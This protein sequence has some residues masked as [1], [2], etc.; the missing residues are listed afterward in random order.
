LKT[1]M[2]EQRN[3]SSGAPHVGLEIADS[4]TRLTVTL[5]AAAG[6]RR[7]H[8]RLPTAP[9]PAAALDAIHALIARALAD[10]ATAHT[11]TTGPDATGAEDVSGA[12]DDDVSGNGDRSASLDASDTP[13]TPHAIGVAFWGAVDAARGQLAGTFGARLASGWEGFPL[14]ERL[15]TRWGGPVRVETATNA[16]ALAEAQLGAGRGYDGVFYML[17]GRSVTSA[18]VIG[19]RVWRGA[20]GR[21]GML[22]HW[23][24]YPEADAAIGQAPRCICGARGHLDPIASAQSL[25]R[26]MIGRA[27]DSDESHA[28]MLAISGRRA[29]AMT[30]P[31]VV[32][33]AAAGDPVAATVLDDALDPLSVALANLVAVLDPGVI[34]IG[35]PLAEAGDR[36]YT[37]LRAHVAALCAPYRPGVDTPPIVAGALEPFAA[38]RGAALL[39]GAAG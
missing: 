4:A 31:Q 9:E 5:G 28:A 32:A 29:E 20:S 26:T 3:L 38:L 19:G 21:A 2:V 37:P 35:G 7:W 15:A 8:A 1:I 6:A 24:A 25:T 22:G 33:L 34:V 39:A 16:A 10:A 13:D 27:S 12:G 14:A 23:L 36:F 17:L 18:L 11:P 30:A